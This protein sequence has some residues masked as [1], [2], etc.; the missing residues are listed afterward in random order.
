MD[1]IGQLTGGVAHDFNNVLTVITGT[2]E[3]LQDGLA[4]KPQLAAIA[5]LIDDAA[6]RGA[7]ITSQ[8]L[9]FARRQPLEPREIEINGLVME[10]AKL[11][12]PMLG[13]HVEIETVLAPDAWGVL[14]DPSQLTAAIVNL[15]VNARDAMS[16]GGK[17]TIETANVTFDEASASTDSEMKPGQFVIIAVGDTGHGIPAD[18]RDR[19]FEPFFT[20]KGVGR[21]TGLGLS[22]VYGFA[23]QTGGTVRIDS[24]EGRGTSV[25]LYLPRAEGVAARAGD[26]PLSTPAV[27][28][29][30]HETI[31][32]V[33]DDALVRGYVIAQLGGL[34]YRTLVASDGAAALAL[35]DQGAEFDLLFTDVIMPGGMNGRQLADA[36]VARRPGMKVLYTSGYTDDAIVHEGHLDPGVALLRKPYRKADLAQKI[37][38]VLGSL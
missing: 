30:Q 16:G 10:T 24:E 36:V 33:E 11:L 2:I 7:S 19:V 18:I 38:E 26:E 21:G 28:L 23:K 31:L 14:A 3:I 29:G 15:A 9:T 32:V 12:M 6:T 34:G 4:D 17:L 13:E 8:L 37:R 25:K 35:V 27:P 5:Q 20:T 1:A 22:M